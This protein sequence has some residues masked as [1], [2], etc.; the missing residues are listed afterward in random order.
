MKQIR[1]ISNLVAEELQSVLEANGVT[2]DDD[3]F[4][5][6]VSEIVGMISEAVEEGCGGKKKVKEAGCGKG[7]GEDCEDDEVVLEE[8]EVEEVYMATE[9]TTLGGQ[10]V[11][12]G[13]FV[14]IDEI[15]DDEGTIEITIYDADGEVK[16]EDVSATYDEI[17]A[18]SDTAE[19][20][21]FDEDGE[22]VEEAVHIKGGKKVK[23][24]AA[25][26]KLRAKLKAKKGNGVN[27]FTIK[28][29][30]IVKKSADQ[31]R[32]DKKKSKV[33]A[34]QMKKFAKKRS[35]S[36]KKAAKLNSGCAGGSKKKVVE[37]FDITSGEMT[38]AVEAG[39]VISYNDGAISVVRE[40]ATLVKG[41]EVSESFMDTCMS[42]GVVEDIVESPEEPTNE[43]SLLTFKSDKGFVLVKEGTEIPMG[44]RIRTRAFLKNEGFDVTSEMLDK[45][46]EGE[47][48]TL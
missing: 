27:K 31:I 48:V 30:K 41:L 33:F 21:A 12:A 10:E 19:P 3:M 23:V 7:D 1:K 11:V 29:G 24:S 42:E 28:N 14:E 6:R 38:F 25:V 34:K 20:V 32:A 46:S 45:A 15:D 9:D 47:L 37:G 36:L 39:D 13:D 22:P 17:N 16:A 35:K 5:G 43:A 26:E 2:V 8:V 44:N 4:E 40:G 18:F